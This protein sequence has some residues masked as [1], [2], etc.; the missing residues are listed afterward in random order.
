MV[1]FPQ[2]LKKVNRYLINFFLQFH[3]FANKFFLVCKKKT[4]EKKTNITGKN[5]EP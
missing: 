2:Y 3:F 1:I 4:K 5:S